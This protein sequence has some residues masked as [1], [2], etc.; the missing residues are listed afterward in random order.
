MSPEAN[1]PERFQSILLV[2]WMIVASMLY[3]IRPT[4]SAVELLTYLIL[5]RFLAAIV[6]MLCEIGACF[7]GMDQSS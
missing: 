7:L 3:L 2:F 6:A 5:S 1:S 4:S